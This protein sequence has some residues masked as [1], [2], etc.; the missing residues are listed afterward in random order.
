MAGIVIV[1]HSSKI[2]E[3]VLELAEQMTQG[4]VKMKA[5][6]GTSDGRIGTD[7]M[8]IRE[9]ILEVD[10]GIGILVFMDLGSAI[11]STETALDFLEE[12]VKGRVVLVDAPLVEGVLAAAI[13]AT[14]T[15]DIE[16][17]ESV[18]QGA[19]NMLKIH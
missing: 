9:A 4:K 11:M 18:A 1:S 14:I 2:A 8:K 17:I 5:A 10:D 3:G 16:E 15:D 19:K 6:G 7:A 13:Q 12:E